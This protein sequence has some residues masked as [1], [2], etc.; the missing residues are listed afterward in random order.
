MDYLSIGVKFHTRIVCILEDSSLSNWDDA[1]VP[2]GIVGVS[3]TQRS[4]HF[5]KG[6]MWCG[7]RTDTACLIS[8]SGR[9]LGI[10][11]APAHTAALRR[12]GALPSANPI[13][14]PPQIQRQILMASLWQA[15]GNITAVL[16]ST[17][18]PR[19]FQEDGI[20][21]RRH[22]ILLLWGPEWGPASV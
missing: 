7:L 16:T 14:S 1:W 12:L 10:P 18:P 15:S 11:S 21:L 20:M 8:I 4:F 5:F 19:C 9:Q 3:N 22:A 17:L 13:R 6:C 2:V